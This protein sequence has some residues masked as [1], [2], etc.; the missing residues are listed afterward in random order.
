MMNEDGLAPFNS[1]LIIPHSSF[2]YLEPAVGRAVPVEEALL[3]VERLA[4]HVAEEARGVLAERGE[5]RLGARLRAQVCA[6]RVL[7]Q[8]GLRG[9]GVAPA[10]LLVAVQHDEQRVRGRDPRALRRRRELLHALV[11]VELARVGPLD[12]LRV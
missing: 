11:R 9:V 4:Y 7:E 10:R 12:L 1:S 8:V 3:A 5:L 2:P 6:A